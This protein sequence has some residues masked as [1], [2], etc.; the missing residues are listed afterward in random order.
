MNIRQ[1][2]FAMTIAAAA[3]SGFGAERAEAQSVTGCAVRPP[4]TSQVRSA[5]VMSA[6]LRDYLETSGAALAIVARVGSDQSKRGLKYTHAAFAWRDHPKGRWT[7]VQELNA[8]G[9]SRSTI[10]DQG[11][12]Q[13]FLD[14]PLNYDAQIIVPTAPLGEAIIAS[15]KNGDG[16]RVHNPHYNVVS[17]PRST[18]YQNSNEWLLEVVA[19]AQGRLR[20]QTIVT[21]EGAQRLHAELG[22]RGSEAQVGFFEQLFGGLFSANVSFADHPFDASS[23][24]WFEFVSVR[25]IK[26][27]LVRLNQTVSV[28]DLTGPTS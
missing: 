28:E 6:R 3:W 21:R 18:M 17:Y 10:Y 12:M 20:N 2:I 19:I 23:N 1:F 15:L 14:D 27:Y 13:F 26:D 4:S 24:G 11:L 8:C 5:A 9:T 16:L 22:F 25:S 7:V